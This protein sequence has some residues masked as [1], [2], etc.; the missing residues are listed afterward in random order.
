[1]LQV[2]SNLKPDKFEPT[3]VKETSD[4]LYVTYKSPFFG[5]VDDGKA[6]F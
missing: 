5:F 2:V 4:Y 1:M 3:I 6:L